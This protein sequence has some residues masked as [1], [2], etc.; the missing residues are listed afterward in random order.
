[1]VEEI[2]RE[3][4]APV[5]L[6]CVRDL[7]FE[8]RIREVVREEGGQLMLCRDPADVPAVKRAPVLILVEMGAADQVAWQ[9]FIQE[10]RRRWPDTPLI[11]F[12]AHVDVEARRAARDAGC[13]HVWSRSR[14]TRELPAWLRAR[15]GA[16]SGIT[17]CEEAPGER[18]R[19]GLRL[20]NQGQYF[21]CHEV[22]EEAWFADQ[23]PCRDLY[24]GIL[25]LAVALHHIEEGNFRGAAKMLRR[26][27]EKLQRLPD[28]CQGVSVALLRERIRRLQRALF[29]LGPDRLQ[30]FPRDLFPGIELSLP[31]GS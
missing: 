17:G 18:V 31:E 27:M 2:A 28:V 12:G 3:M 20:F 11:A 8:V 7:F 22:L 24:Q 10:A 13:Q 5:V 6:A 4:S 19:H 15:L 26:A 30:E 14:L 16:A 21:E 23:R 25:Q 29:D 9:E 1:M